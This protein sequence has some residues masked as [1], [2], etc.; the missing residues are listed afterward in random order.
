LSRRSGGGGGCGRE[1]NSVA[2]SGS[3]FGASNEPML[4][5]FHANKILSL[6]CLALLSFAAAA[7]AKEP[8]KCWIDVKTGKRVPSV[9]LSTVPT[10]IP[11]QGK[12]AVEL[13][14][15]GKT[16][17]NPVTKQNYALE[18]GGCWIDVKT[19]K[20]A[21]GVPLS[22][23]P[24][25]IPEQGKYAVELSNNGKTAFNPVTKQNYALV[26]CPPPGTAQPT[27]STTDKVTDAL[28]TIGNSVSIDIGG[29]GYSSDHD[30]R[31][32]GEDRHRTADK[33]STDKTKTHKTSPTTTHK[34]VTSACKC[35]P[36]TC[37]PCT[38]H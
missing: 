15:N 23:V 2:S 13:S 33:V 14:N 16:A 24:T 29:G 12:Y 21:P 10:N 30:E 6:T 32:H 3:L 37:S 26:P 17:F 31:H 4:N 28:R 18:P 7:F 11:E 20:Q 1:A 22:T 25:N 34:T 5:L 36:C 19:G 38:C 9:P 35:H 8:C 27:P